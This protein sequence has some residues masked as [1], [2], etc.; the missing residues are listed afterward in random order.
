MT[1]KATSHTQVVTEIEKLPHMKD[2][3]IEEL[4]AQHMNEEQQRSL[5]NIL[6]VK[7]KKDVDNKEAITLISGGELE[8]LIREKVDA[9]DLKNIVAKEAELTSPKPNEKREKVVKT[10]PEMGCVTPPTRH[11]KWMSSGGVTL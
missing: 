1:P 6:E 4:M 2:M 8:E 7:P 3:S 5:P 10:F 9:N 11:P